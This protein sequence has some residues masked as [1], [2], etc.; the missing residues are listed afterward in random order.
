MTGLD[1]LA[2]EQKARLDKTPTP[3][4]STASSTSHRS[5]TNKLR[6]IQLRKPDAGSPSCTSRPCTPA[7]SRR[8]RGPGRTLRQ[9]REQI[10]AYSPPATR[11]TV[12][13][14]PST[15]ASRKPDDSPTTSTTHTFHR[16]RI[17]LAADATRP[18]RRA[19]SHA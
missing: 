17:F 12:R 4:T 7:P 2:S 6:A 11:T 3:A 15:A 18:Y 9:W 16:H 10:L 13:P 19:T 14:R 1:H 5:S 8:S